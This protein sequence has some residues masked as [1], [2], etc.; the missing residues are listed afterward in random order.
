MFGVLNIDFQLGGRGLSEGQYDPL[1]PQQ[2]DG[3]RIRKQRQQPRRMS[4]QTLSRGIS[5]I[6]LSP[7]V[8]EHGLED[9]PNKNMTAESSTAKSDKPVG[10][11]NKDKEQ[12]L[13][14]F[15]SSPSLK[16]TSIVDETK[17]S[18]ARAATPPSRQ[19]LTKELHFETGIKL[20]RTRTRP[21]AT[22]TPVKEAVRQDATRAAPPKQTPPKFQRDSSD[23]ENEPPMGVWISPPP[24]PKGVSCGLAQPFPNHFKPRPSTANDAQGLGKS[25]SGAHPK[26]QAHL[27]EVQQVAPSTSHQLS[28][29]TMISRASSRTLERNAANNVRRIVASE[30]GNRLPLPVR[31]HRISK[32]T[33]EDFSR[34]DG[35]T[36]S[37]KLSNSKDPLTRVSH[38]EDLASLATLAQALDALDTSVEIDV[39]LGTCPTNTHVPASHPN[40]VSKSEHV[41]IAGIKGHETT[42][43]LTQ[44]SGTSNNKITSNPTYSITSQQRQVVNSYK[45]KY[46]PPRGSV[47][48]LAAKFNTADSPPL[49]PPLTN[50]PTKSLRLNAQ[51]RFD[52]PKDSLVA[53][54]TTNPPSPARS[55]KSVISDKTPRSVR[56]L[57]PDR[58]PNKQAPSIPFKVSDSAQELSP[59]MVSG[60]D[61]HASPI[62][63]SSPCKNSSSHRILK[64]S[65]KDS[66]PLRSVPKP[67]EGNSQSLSSTSVNCSNPYSVLLKPINKSDVAEMPT[68]ATSLDLRPAPPKQVHIPSPMEIPTNMLDGPSGSGS[69]GRVLPR[70]DQ[71]P[72]ARHIQ[73]S[74]PQSTTGV[75][76]VA[77]LPHSQSTSNDTAL[78][79]GPVKAVTSPVPGRSNSMLHGQLQT[80]QRQLMSKEEEIRHL[81]QQ[82]EMRGNLEIGTLNEQL[83]EAKREIQMWKTRAEVAEKQVEVMTKLSSRSNSRQ[84]RNPVVMKASDQSC[85][86]SANYS[87]DGAVVADRIRRALHGLDGATSKLGS[88]EESS[89]TVIRDIREAITGSEFSIWVEQTMNALEDAVPC[90]LE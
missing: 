17:A 11:S 5:K 44:K 63:D 72:V 70:P 81:K 38:E 55:Q 84:M 76:K 48:A 59:F 51:S 64:S 62:Q 73:F 56:S 45:G 57:A 69:L 87:E 89:E 8:E 41:T 40:Q 66:T 75:V 30:P 21:L 14:D 77:D 49:L 22:H 65:L 28:P 88:S 43:S 90:E 68:L 50:S 42:E 52:S 4:S 82:L 71:P 24:G 54:Y 19:E 53:P 78:I 26:Q 6:L 86:S 2:N 18:L 74:R 37:S 83:R 29:G 25:P 32:S 67:L 80:L 7:T 3:L 9:S 85:Q 33:M 36:G 27:R 61:K 60:S 39:K 16:G 34:T 10:S 35:M 31:S 20:P 46:D 79:S 1:K 12:A 58:N 15:A 47:K 23:K 13:V